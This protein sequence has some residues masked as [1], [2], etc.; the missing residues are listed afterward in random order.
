M[1][2]I[3]WRLVSLGLVIALT[4]TGGNP[5]QADQQV[6]A[7][8]YLDWSGAVLS[9]TSGISQVIEPLEIS[10]FT[11][12]EA[13]WV[14]DNASDGGYGGIH[15]KGTLADGTVSDL[16]IFSIR[17]AV[18]AVPGAGAGCLP[19]SGEGIGYSCRIPVT[20]VAGNK[21]EISFK[22]DS[23][24]GPKWWIATIS[25]LAKGT[26][27]VIGSI[28]AN[29]TMAMASN[30]TNSIEYWGPAVLC[31]EVG[32]A[33]AK[34]YVPTSDNPDIEVFWPKFSRPSN[35]C[36][37]SAGDTPPRGYIGAA[38]IRFGGYYQ[39]ASTETLPFTKTKAQLAREKAE[40]V[41]LAASLKKTTITCFK[42]K[43]VKKV[44]A[45]KPLCPKGY[46]K[47]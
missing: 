31:D 25:D 41:K 29:T 10:P 24:R 2:T 1:R 3:P 43:L 17:N 8:A 45:Y 38:V 27:R 16:A 6:G 35:S 39:F 42:G 4:I 22:M 9:E 14:W 44:T 15:S 11:D 34:F 30:W 32:E 20:L 19:F 37:M 33:S 26:K 18:G 13:G 12:W 46:K 28:E 5:A 47:R 7:A 21:Y 40:A 23:T 36:V